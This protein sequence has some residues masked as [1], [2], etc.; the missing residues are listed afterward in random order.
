MRSTIFS[1]L[2]REFIGL[3]GEGKPE[4]GAG[5]ATRELLGRF[6]QQLEAHGLSLDDAVRNRLFARDR[7]SWQEG[8]PARRDLLS[9][10]AR[11]VSSS[12]IDPGRFDSAAAVALD[13]LAMRPRQPGATKTAREYDPPRPPLRYL[14]YDSVVFLSGVTSEAA[15]LEAQ[16]AEILA[17]IGESLAMA[18][19]AWDRVVLLSCFLQR[20]QSVSALQGLLRQSIPGGVPRLECELVEG[21]AGEAYSIEIEATAVR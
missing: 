20:G 19:T 9:N 13:L 10:G 16:V 6:G 4:L 3:S 15:R 12:F 17:E 14:D 1:W 2:D 8:S 7:S 21:F 5:E 11:T 18:G